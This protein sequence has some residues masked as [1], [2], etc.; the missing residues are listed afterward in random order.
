[1]L[2]VSVYGPALEHHAHYCLF[3]AAALKVHETVNKFIQS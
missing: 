2:A 3:V 1:M